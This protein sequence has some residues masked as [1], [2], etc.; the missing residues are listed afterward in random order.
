MQ[1]NKYYLHS[2]HSY[3][4]ARKY[5]IEENRLVYFYLENLVY[6]NIFTSLLNVKELGTK[7]HHMIVA[8]MK[9]ICSLQS[10]LDF[11]YIFMT[12]V[13]YVNT[14]FVMTFIK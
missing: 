1:Q 11:Y 12:D 7:F 2:H 13:Y 14:S 5:P 4:T 9:K 10:N 6:Y 3:Q 8:D